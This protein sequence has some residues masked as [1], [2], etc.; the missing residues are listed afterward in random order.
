MS[1]MALKSIFEAVFGRKVAE[2]G[3]P[4]SPERVTQSRRKGGKTHQ[5]FSPDPR[6]GSGE[7]QAMGLARPTVGLA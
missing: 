3:D 7:T 1:F 4:K 5:W 6:C 2:E